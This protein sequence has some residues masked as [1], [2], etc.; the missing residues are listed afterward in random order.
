MSN[1]R[2]IYEIVYNEMGKLLDKL[3]DDFSK[4]YDKKK[5]NWILSGFDKIIISNMVFVSSFESKYGNMFEE[6]IRGIVALNFGEDNV[7]NT[8]RG[9]GIT[10]D[11]YESFISKHTFN[12]QRIISKYDKKKNEGTISQFRED[13]VAQGRGLNRKPSTLTQSELP[14]LLD[15]K[16]FISEKIMAQ[17][18]DL[19]YFDSNDNNYKL[20]EIKAGGDL[21]SSNAPKNIEKMLKIYSTLGKKNANLY[22]ATLY[23]KNGEGN[24]WSGVV[25]KHLGDDSILIGREFWNKILPHIEFTEFVK[26]YEKAFEDIGFNKTLSNLIN[27]T[28]Q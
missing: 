20:F 17:P 16:I 2:E 19:L 9:I 23:H 28:A 21:D 4:N 6:I 7:P 22:F 10:E 1:Q 26:I 8:V 25:K 5:Y 13:R 27:Q 11:E 14:K 24:N 12:G 3:I 15:E 18:V